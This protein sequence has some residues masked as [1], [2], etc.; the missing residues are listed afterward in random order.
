MMNGDLLSDIGQFFSS[1][2]QDFTSG[3]IFF[4]GP[5][6]IMLAVL[7]VL[8]TS[9]VVYYV[10]KILRDSRAWQLLKGLAMII[11]FALICS[12]I[13]LDT[14]GF[15]LN[16]TI[17]VLAIAFVVIFQPELR[18]AL[19]TVGRNSFN[20]ISSAIAQDDSRDPAGSVHNLI[21]AI[22]RACEK[23]SETFTGA[24]IIIERSTR[25][26]DFAEQENV[27]PLD[28]AVSSTFLQ[29]IFYKGSPLHDG[30]VLIRNGRV[31]AARVHV[32]L[33]DNYHLR[34]DYGTRHRAAIGASEIGDTIAVV[35]SEERGTISLSL[36]GRLYTLD[37][38][39]ALRTLLHKLL[40]PAKAAS[41]ISGWFRGGKHARSG[42]KTQSV[43]QKK[44]GKSDKSSTSSLNK[45]IE[46]S[47]EAYESVPVWRR[48]FYRQSSPAGPKVT[49]KQKVVLSLASVAIAIV[50]WLYVQVTINPVDNRTFTVSLTYRGV[51]TAQ[52]NGF[53]IQIPVQTVQV[54]VVGRKNTVTALRASDITAYV[55]FSDIDESGLISIP[56]EIDTGTLLYTRPTFI[57]PSS[58]TVSVRE[59]E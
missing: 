45:D 7:D 13:G 59:A 30:A 47:A 34:R 44:T 14:V 28:A 56:V 23:M 57:T 58:V 50:L 8:A 36:E 10:L 53:N 4:G 21:E 52:E 43:D 42:K 46:S 17:S 54:N 41:G 37:N 39:D 33:S 16:N 6:D 18:R 1:L 32:P 48:I 38:G 40:S 5:L 15:L 9:L 24:L 20:M 29:Q 2:L 25:L 11:S 19:E 31:S 49:R 35:V 26:G 12:L 3:L 51:E 27:V 55:D 22:V